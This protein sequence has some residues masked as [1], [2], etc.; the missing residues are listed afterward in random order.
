[1][2]SCR[3]LE[4]TTSSRG[5]RNVKPPVPQTV[6][7]KL[8]STGTTIPTYTWHRFIESQITNLEFGDG[9]AWEF[10]YE[11]EQTGARRRW[12]TAWISE[13]MEN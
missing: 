9:E 8:V 10:I 3:G 2:E 5:C 1:M 7:A 6:R 13:G 12:G 4:A 11:C